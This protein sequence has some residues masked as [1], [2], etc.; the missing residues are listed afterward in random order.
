MKKAIRIL[1]L[2]LV[3][4][5]LVVAFTGCSAIA[6]YQIQG[7]WRDSTGTTGY[8]FQDN[9]VCIITFIDVSLPVVGEYNGSIS[10][11]YTVTKG[12]DGNMYVEIS[13]TIPIISYSIT[14]SYIFEVSGS[15]LTL[16]DPDSGSS[17][18]YIEYEA[19]EAESE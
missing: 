2:G 19:A 18:I 13:Y 1:S 9:N 3:A 8:E 12:D 16:T 5:M 17:T 6:Q 11:I 15:T 7:S 10:G 4:I 14:S